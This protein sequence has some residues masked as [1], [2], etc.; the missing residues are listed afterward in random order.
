M[1]APA[2]LRHQLEH[3]LTA[4]N[5]SLDDAVIEQLLAYQALLQRWNASYNLTAI[6]DPAEQISRHILDSLTILPHVRGQRLADIGTGPGLPGLILAI[7][8]PGREVVLVDSNG[9]KV[10]FLREAI[11][12]LGLQGVRAIQSRVEQVEGEFDCI[13][14]RA[15]ASLA[16]MLG[17]GGHLLAPD[18]LWLA[19]KG[20]HP[21]DEL[22]AMPAG[23]ELRRSIPLQVP[24]VEGERHLLEI[25]R[26]PSPE[27]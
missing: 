3:G 18:G 23:F 10:R 14:A 8:A 20:R 19:M 21:D 11:R 7:A 4:L 2:S 22:E 9:K 15:F 25:A 16:D 12:S 17:W 26:R 13:T 27:C 1:T 5:L 24:G 6:R